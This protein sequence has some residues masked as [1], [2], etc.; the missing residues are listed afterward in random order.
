MT[1]P[2]SPVTEWSWPTE[3]CGYT[4]STDEVCHVAN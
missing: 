1:S 3:F 2:T 4:T